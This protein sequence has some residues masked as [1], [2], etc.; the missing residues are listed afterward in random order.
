MTTAYIGLGSN[1]G[2]RMANLGDAVARIACMPDTHVDHASH[3]FES[4]PAY[5]TDQ[6]PFANAVIEIETLISPETVLAQLQQ[7]EEDMGRVRAEENG[8]RVIDLDILLFGDEEIVTEELTIPHPRMLER[9]FVVTPLLEIAPRLRMP[10]GSRIERESAT[11]GLVTSELGPMPDNGAIDNEPVLTT[12]WVTVAESSAQQDFSAG[13]DMGL[14]FKAE[15][16]EEANIPHAWDPYEPESSVDPFGL[17]ITFKLLVPSGDAPRAVRLFSDLESAEPQFPANLGVESSG[18]DETEGDEMEP[19]E[20][21]PDE[22]GPDE[23][24]LE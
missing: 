9:A 19:D 5:Q 3:V 6:P 20:T 23:V 10:D 17:P 4:E 13:W 8:P 1:V 22:T 7:I 11:V 2:D 18:A 24:D 21:E 14:V 15:A 12:G 16:L